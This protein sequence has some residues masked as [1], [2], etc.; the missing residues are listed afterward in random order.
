MLQPFLQGGL[1][2]VPRGLSDGKG[3]QSSH[4]VAAP[5]HLHHHHSHASGRGT[6]HVSASE[7]HTLPLVTVSLILTRVLQVTIQSRNLEC[8]NTETLHEIQLEAVIAC[9]LLRGP[10]MLV[11]S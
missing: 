11:P 3:E 6:V 8:L 4:C 9:E 2:K 5:H 1:Q 7:Q 10:A